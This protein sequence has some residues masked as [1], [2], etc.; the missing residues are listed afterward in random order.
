MIYDSKTLILTNDADLDGVSSFQED[1]QKKKNER[2]LSFS[3][4]LSF[5]QNGREERCSFD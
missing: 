4:F 5:S 2:E 1:K 3:M